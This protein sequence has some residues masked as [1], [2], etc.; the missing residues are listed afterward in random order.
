[1]IRTSNIRNGF[2]DTANTFRT[3]EEVFKAWN[4]R[5]TPRKGDVLLTREAPLGEVGMLNTDESVFLGQRIILYRA[6]VEVMN[7]RLLLQ[8]L[9]SSRSLEQFKFVGAGSLH[10]HMRVHDAMKIKIV[11]PPREEQDG[12][13]SRIDHDRSSCIAL[14][15]KLDRQIALLA[16]RRRALITAAV[17]GQIDVTAARG[18]EVP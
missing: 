3:S 17:T 7:P 12:L 14:E 2:V 4:R 10:A 18:V 9:L 15:A 5:G 16:E 6:N 11:C 1:M 13:A 8:N